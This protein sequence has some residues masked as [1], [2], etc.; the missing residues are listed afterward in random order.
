MDLGGDGVG[1]GAAVGDVELDAKVPVRAARVVRRRQ[2]DPA[3]NNV[4][5]GEEKAIEQ[6][7]LTVGADGADEGGDGGRGHEAALAH[8]QLAHPV[9][10]RHSDDQRR[11]LRR[12]VPSKL[13]VKTKAG[14]ETRED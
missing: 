4:S 10:R 12:E 9:R 1:G 5:C 3:S 13:A 7:E 11:R 6:N 2:Q 8:H 14:T